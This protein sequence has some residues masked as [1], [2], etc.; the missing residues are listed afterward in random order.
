MGYS[1]D[2]DL[3]SVPLFLRVEGESMGGAASQFTH[4]SLAAS[5]NLPL[6]LVAI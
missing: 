3:T 1:H 2:Q 4:T 6:F 5:N